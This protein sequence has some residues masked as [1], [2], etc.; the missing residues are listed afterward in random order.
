[1][2]SGPAMDLQAGYATNPSAVN[3]VLTNPAGDTFVVRNFPQPGGAW[4]EQMIRAGAAAG[5]MRVRSPLIHDVSQGIRVA[6]PAGASP[7]VIYQ[8]ICQP[9]QPQDSLIV[10][11][12]GGASE[13]DV[14]VIGTYYS[15]LPGASAR[16]YDYPTIQGSVVNIEAIQV[17]VTSSATIGA[18]TSALIN[19][20]QDTTRANTDYAVL[21]YETDTALAA[22]AIYGPDTANLR[23]G[24]PGFVQPL[25]TRDYF[26]RMSRLTGR[27][28]IPVFNSAN[29]GSTNVAVIAN[30]ASV[31]A[32]VTL[33]CAQVTV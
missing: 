3:T 10:D 26:V 29:K 16:L 30:T 24:G 13:T 7:N 14:C 2:A 4:L 31:A 9:L 12:T 1:M 5:V 19:V 11:T 25:E 15:A 32:N 20:T 23:C 8:G 18:W 21:G 27:P 33:I 22:I 6:I 17:A 28:H